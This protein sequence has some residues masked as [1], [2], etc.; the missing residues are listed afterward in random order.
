[1][2][3]LLGLLGTAS[4]P[5]ST[6]PTLFKNKLSLPPTQIHKMII[7][8]TLIGEMIPAAALLPPVH[9]R[10]AGPARH[11]RRPPGALASRIQAESEAERWSLSRHSSGCPTKASPPLGPLGTVLLWVSTLLCLP[12]RARPRPIR[13]AGGGGCCLLV[14]VLGPPCHVLGPSQ[15]P[16]VRSVMTRAF[17]NFRRNSFSRSILCVQDWEER[18]GEAVSGAALVAARTQSHSHVPPRVQGPLL[19]TTLRCSMPHSSFPLAPQSCLL[20][21]CN[22]RRYRLSNLARKDFN[23]PCP[24][25]QL[26]HL[27]PRHPEDWQGESAGP[28]QAWGW[29]C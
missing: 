28:A 6:S 4:G 26:G 22:V 3:P 8:Q 9:L 18:D 12:G 1:M 24:A 29:T 20:I 5:N 16:L 7:H 2:G 23:L 13:W 19:T 25:V 14:A 17:T 11:S 27:S 21:S 15:M 10:H